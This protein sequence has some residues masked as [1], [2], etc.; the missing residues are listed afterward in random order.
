MSLNDFRSNT[1]PA[2]PNN[3]G[4]PPGLPLNLNV[5]QG[6]DEDCVEDMLINYNEKFKN[7]GTAMYRE[8]CIQQTL[9]CL[10]GK[11]KPNALLIGP[12]GVGKTK[13]VEDIAFR[14]VTKDPLI[15]DQLKDFTIYELPLAN[16]VAGSS[17]VGQVEA[18]L[19]EV[20]AFCSDPANKVIL[21]IDEIHVVVSGSATYDKIAQILKPAL[22]RGEIRVIGATTSQEAT[23][24]RDD[25]A[26]NRRFSRVLVDELTKEQTTEILK[27]ALPS[28]LLHYKKVTI[29][30][31]A[32]EQCVEISEQYKSAGNHRPDTAITLLDRTMAEAI[33]NKNV[34]EHQ[35]MVTGNTVLQQVLQSVKQVPI[36]DKNLRSTAIRLATGHSQQAELDRDSLDDRLS[37]I[38]GQDNAIREIKDIVIRNSLNLFPKTKPKSMLFIGPSGV[39][40]TEVV[41]IL[42]QELISTKPI[43]LNMTEYSSP[44]T[45]N[46]VIGSPAGYVGSDSNAELPFDPLEANPYQLILLDEFEKAHS[47]VQRLFMGILDEGTLTNS[48]GTTYDVSK[49]IIVATTNAAYQTISNNIGFGHTEEEGTQGTASIS[50]L[51]HWFDPALLN[52]FEHKI[53]FNEITKQAYKDILSDIYASEITDVKA[54]HSRLTMPDTLPEE[55]CDKMADDTY[56]PAFGAR[57]AKSTIRKYIEDTV[58]AAPQAASNSLANA[59]TPPETETEPNE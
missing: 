25:P 29:T 38:K 47:S 36:T 58:L 45:I 27:V 51:S 9:A 16:L 59:A 23:K 55:D 48:R 50:D 17:L 35:A 57:P 26:F 22:A 13:I 37:H 49:S 34:Q 46:R 52:R 43:I 6:F 53:I 4:M 30:E 12:A 2:N 14:I 11:T 15:P 28:F 41:K 54:R 39:G 31:E 20:M 3:P 21:F 42:S 18:K 32:L 24:L 19:Q 8:Q 33:I 10:I 56:E 40:K 1:P 5:P 7:G 44:E